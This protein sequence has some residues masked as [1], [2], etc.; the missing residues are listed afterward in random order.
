MVKEK[1]TILAMM[2]RIPRR[3]SLSALQE[4]RKIKYPCIYHTSYQISTQG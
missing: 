1:Y 3:I 2:H 4:K